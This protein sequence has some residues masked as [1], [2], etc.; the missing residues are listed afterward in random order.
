MNYTSPYYYKTLIKDTDVV[1]DT[2]NG[3]GIYV[4]SIETTLEGYYD[5]YIAA[6]VVNYLGIYIFND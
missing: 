4:T 2:E 6:T 5:I 3:I 1:E